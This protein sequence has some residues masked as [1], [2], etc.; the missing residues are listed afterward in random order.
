V[1]PPVIEL[2]NTLYK[3]K[4]IKNDKVQKEALNIL[5][6]QRAENVEK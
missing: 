2:P 1:G 6:V 5:E 3:K 4:K